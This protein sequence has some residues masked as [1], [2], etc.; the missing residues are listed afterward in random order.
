[1]SRSKKVQKPVLPEPPPAR[2]VDPDAL[3]KA[4]KEAD[5]SQLELALLTGVSPRTL[6][7]IESGKHAGSPSLRD[8]GALADVLGL[9][10]DRL[11]PKR[12]R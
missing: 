1:M 3:K 2:V 12:A 4:R 9:S 10:L 7:R 6:S 11:A 8:A 5:L